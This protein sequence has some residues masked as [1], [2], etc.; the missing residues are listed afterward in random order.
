MSEPFSL[1]M[2]EPLL[3]GPLDVSVTFMSENGSIGWTLPAGWTLDQVT[4]HPEEVVC[5]PV[6]HP[7]GREDPTEYA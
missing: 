2:P 5:D 1:P 6:R 3:F 7:E 4:Y